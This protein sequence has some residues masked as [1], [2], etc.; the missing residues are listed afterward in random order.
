MIACVGDVVLGDGR[1][2]IQSMFKRPL[3]A[4]DDSHLRRL[5]NMGCDM[6]RFSV[7]D[8]SEEDI[9]RF[10]KRCEGLFPIIS[11][12]QGNVRQAVSSLDAGCAAIR[13][14]PANFGMND[15]D[16][17]ASLAIDKSAAIRIGINS[18]SLKDASTQAVLDYFDKYIGF[19]E[20]RNFRNL[21]LSVKSSD[22]MKTADLNKLVSERYGYPMHVGLT[23][24]GGVCASAVRSTLVLHD[25]IEC[26]RVD[27]IRYSISSDERS[28]IRC[29]YEFLRT[30][31]RRNDDFQMISCPMCARAG[32]DTQAFGEFVED[33]VFDNFDI[34][35]L[36]LKIA[37]MGCPV[38]GVREAEGADIAVCASKGEY[39]VFVAGERREST[40]SADVFKDLFAA[41]VRSRIIGKSGG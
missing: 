32:A 39:V 41:A 22:V 9:R 33:F 24:A 17:I 20:S 29:A 6:M 15:L 38:N 28:E 35:E 25:L 21:V 11:D 1:I 30:L 27:T 8:E 34:R 2:A 7:S 10:V 12:I 23:E 13:I 5:R 14:N 26:A 4:Y 18:G 3:R 16:L 36:N 31:G 19:F 37:V 40:H